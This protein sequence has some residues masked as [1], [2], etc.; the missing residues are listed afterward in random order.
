MFLNYCSHKSRWCERTSFATHILNC[1]LAKVLPAIFLR[2]INVSFCDLSRHKQYKVL[3]T[4]H[5]NEVIVS[6]IFYF[7]R[8]ASKENVFGALQVMSLCF[9]IV[10]RFDHWG[11]R[12]PSRNDRCTIPPQSKFRRRLYLVHTGLYSHISKALLL[13]LFTNLGNFI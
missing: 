8:V 5:T 6:I 11:P 2:R 9:K 13:R 10:F 12:L 4:L 1:K 3:V 7:L